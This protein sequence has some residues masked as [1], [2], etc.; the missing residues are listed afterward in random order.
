MEVN[1]IINLGAYTN[2]SYKGMA[3]YLLK[4][5]AGHRKIRTTASY[6]YS[7]PSHSGAISEAGS[8]GLA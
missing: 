5:L 8:A 1:L 6:L 2:K 4:T 3:I 7:S